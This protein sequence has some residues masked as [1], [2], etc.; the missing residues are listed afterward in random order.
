MPQNNPKSGKGQTILGLTILT[1]LCGIGAGIYIEQ[2]RMSPAVIAFRPP[3]SIYPVSEPTSNIRSTE[4]PFPLPDGVAPLSPMEV[5]DQ[6]TL[7]DKIDG[8]AE[9]YLSAGFTSLKSQRITQGDD[10]GLW[11]EMFVYDMGNG[12][13]AY[14][15]FSSQRRQDSRPTD[16]THFS[17]GTENALFF[18][19]GPYYIE[20]IASKGTEKS[21]ETMIETAKNYISNSEAKDKSIPELELFPEH[22]LVKGSIVLL[23]SDVF[24]CECL[25]RVFSASYIVG[26]LEATSF[27]SRRNT[28][29]DARRLALEFHDFLIAYGGEDVDYIGPVREAKMVDMLGSYEFIFFRGPFFAGVHEAESRKLA[30][31]LAKSLDQRLSEVIDGR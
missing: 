29:Q 19:H 27:L 26:N 30:E 14:A 25:D 23:T 8:K 2:F 12:A 13:N 18:I 9:F 16:V 22:N 4:T 31:D 15:V 11:M 7:S 3:P 24:G 5:F 28:P 10:A 6:S 21:F 17:Y 1:V 20:I